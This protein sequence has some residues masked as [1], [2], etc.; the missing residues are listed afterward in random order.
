[1]EGGTVL[2]AHGQQPGWGDMVLP[3][4]SAP[5]VPGSCLSPGQSSALASTFPQTL[6]MPWLPPNTILSTGLPRTCW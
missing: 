1:M 4:G 3:P 2:P 6:E 5:V